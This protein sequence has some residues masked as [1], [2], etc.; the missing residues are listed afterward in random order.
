MLVMAIGHIT[1][2]RAWSMVCDTAVC[3]CCLHMRC[4]TGCAAQ[5]ATIAV[6]RTARKC[7]NLVCTRSQGQTAAPRQN[8]FPCTLNSGQWIIKA[9]SLSTGPYRCAACQHSTEIQCMWYLGL[10]PQSCPDSYL[11]GTWYSSA[12]SHSKPASSLCACDQYINSRSQMMSGHVCIH[13]AQCACRSS[14]GNQPSL[15]EEPSSTMLGCGMAQMIGRFT[16][17]FDK[18]AC[19]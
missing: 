17:I 16:R 8:N 9:Q 10:I 12:S 13:P 1:S 18:V 11:Q 15:A 7:E 3:T 19:T 14:A 6:C 2:G 5:I 4:C